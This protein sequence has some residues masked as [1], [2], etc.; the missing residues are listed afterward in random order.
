MRLSR[1]DRSLVA[2]WWFT[3]DRP[4]LAVLVA[5]MGIGCVISLA[6][7]PTVAMKRGLEPFHFAERHVMFAVLGLGVMVAC[8]RLDP[9]Q[10]RRLALVLLVT[11][12]GAMAWLALAGVEI[13]GAR[14]WVFIA[15]QSIQPSEIGK[16]A[17][18]VMVAW[19]LAEAAIRRDMPALPAAAGLAL[20]FSGLLAVQPD[21]GQTALV[22]LVWGAMF[23]VSGQPLKWALMLVP[24]GLAGFGAAYLSFDHVRRR[25]ARFLDPGSGEN[26]QI[27]QAVQSFAE[28][29]IVGRGP[30]EGVI[31]STLPDAHT[32]FIF[33]VIGE[34]YGALACLGL[35]SLYGFVAWRAFGAAF[36]T[37]D[38]FLRLAATGLCLLLVSQAAINM[39]VNVG[40]LPAKGMT[41]PFIS[42]GGSSTLS[43]ALTAGFLLAATRRR[44]DV[45]NVKKP[46]LATS[47]GR[48]SREGA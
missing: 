19:L 12:L 6:A 48:L 23:L 21:I 11:A 44:V 45:G 20:V 22:V 41:L 16:P 2:D 31:K 47:L 46:Q 42:A 9:R 40:L 38:A 10:M 24:A 26:Y 5:L 34:E 15:G 30:G 32:D 4:L 29:G 25:V 13:K 36:R 39:G 28:G 18:V 43:S 14:R 35:L 3:I 1:E 37:T 8:S 27:E 17:L 33:A 7:S